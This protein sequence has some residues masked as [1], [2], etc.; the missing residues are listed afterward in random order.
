MQAKTEHFKELDALRGLAAQF[1]VVAHLYNAF[2]P[3]SSWPLI[4]QELG[5]LARLS[6]IYFF[7]LSGFAITTAIH[8][9][10]LRNG[11]F[12]WLDYA[13]RRVARIY[14][15]F[16]MT[17]LLVG[18]LTLAAFSG[19]SLP[20]VQYPLE[21]NASGTSWLRTAVFLFTS[22]DAITAFDGVVWSLRIE[23]GLYVLAAFLTLA[24]LH[25]GLWRLAFALVTT[26]LAAAFCM[27]LSF[28]L[29]GIVLFASG[30]AAA[31]SLHTLRRL[32]NFWVPLAVIG[33]L[34]LPI[35]SVSLIDD[36]F[37]SLTYQC[38]LGPPIAMSLVYMIHRK[39]GTFSNLLVAS[40]GWSYTLYLTHTPVIVGARA[41]FGNFGLP[42]PGIV[43]SV[44]VVFC[45]FLL[46]NFTA[47]LIAR[48]LERP[49]YF[50]RV[51]KNALG[52]AGR[53]AGLRRA[54]AKNNSQSI[55]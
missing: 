50:T 8:R 54:D 11:Y 26:V 31:L 45:Y 35:L 53:L 39:I 24:L 32:M 37:L 27:R 40:G 5:W 28:A 17:I 1:V 51:I 9:G 47:Y 46:A 12:D 18:I 29:L 44:T 55:V 4:G 25:S 6:V 15:P 33:A 34:A 41:L 19:L 3:A 21:F 20:G 22:N 42:N 48:Y 7:V 38:A 10:V 43:G 36:S 13:I 52:L 16:L 14:P 49:A 2:F 30:A 23:V